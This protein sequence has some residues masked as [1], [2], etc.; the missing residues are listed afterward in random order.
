MYV[1]LVMITPLP[2]CGKCDCYR[3]V[4]RARLVLTGHIMQT[5]LR[6]TLWG[7]AN[8]LEIISV[9]LNIPCSAW[10]LL[11][12]NQPPEAVR[13]GSKLTTAFLWLFFCKSVQLPV[14]GFHHRTERLTRC[15]ECSN[16]NEIN[17][18]C[19]VFS[20]PVL[21][22]CTIFQGWLVWT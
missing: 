22:Q 10:A 6:P 1:S 5:L 19:G 4:P 20:R 9:R 2:V 17:S 18:G 12:E 13:I 11:S 15:T 7:G 8:R 3:L 16:E 21:T 14:A